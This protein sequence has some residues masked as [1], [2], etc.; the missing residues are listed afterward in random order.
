MVS[1]LSVDGYELLCEIESLNGNFEFGSNVHHDKLKGCSKWELVTLQ[2][3]TFCG[4]QDNTK[5][6]HH[7]KNNTNNSHSRPILLFILSEMSYNEQP[8]D[9]SL[10]D[11]RN[12]G[13]LSPLTLNG[14]NKKDA[15]A[16]QDKSFSSS[17]SLA[18]KSSVIMAKET[19]AI[20]NQM[21]YYSTS[22]NAAKTYKNQKL[23][24]G[25]ASVV[26]KYGNLQL[27]DS[28]S[29]RIA[30][31]VPHVNVSIGDESDENIE[32]YL[33]QVQAPINNINAKMTP[34]RRTGK[35]ATPLR[36]RDIIQSHKRSGSVKRT[37]QRNISAS[38]ARQQSSLEKAFSASK[39]VVA[40][41]E[42]SPR[43]AN[44]RT[45][46]E[47]LYDAVKR[48]RRASMQKNANST[49]VNTVEESSAPARGR[50]M[51][52][53]S[54]RVI[55]TKSSMSLYPDRRDELIKTQR[56]ATSSFS[57]ARNHKR[58][59]SCDSA[60]AKIERGRTTSRSSTTNIS[61]LPPAKSR[62]E[63]IAKQ[64]KRQVSSMATARSQSV[65]RK[66][67]TLAIVDEPQDI[68][69]LSV[70]QSCSFSANDRDKLTKR[71]LRRRTARELLAKRNR[72]QAS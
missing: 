68:A 58:N 32:C 39:N 43:P 21:V 26:S 12:K 20:K 29:H 11:R 69:G 72:F 63:L 65:P 44:A 49:R 22:A 7:I 35:T 64:K 61:Q 52:P 14:T 34:P 6:K 4:D 51:V 13:P 48:S 37:V 23:S 42:V 25:M 40:K 19:A 66:S 59:T 54:N 31:I 16:K 57:V 24:I 15:T 50:S 28:N 9:W 56:S 33:T 46:R 70:T 8:S 2:C 41:V 27:D 30:M 67:E 53:N 55:G 62:R 17:T 18:K 3:L 1:L 5:H 47:E 38:P 60:I 10:L 45:R 36:R 71:Q